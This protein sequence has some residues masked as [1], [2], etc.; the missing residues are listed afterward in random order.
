[1]PSSWHQERTT[2]NVTKE[3]HQTVRE[4]KRG[5][6]TFDDLLRAMAAQYEPGRKNGGGD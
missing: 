1:M 3:T 4:L 2:L 5:G 6:E